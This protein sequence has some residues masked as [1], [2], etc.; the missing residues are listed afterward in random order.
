MRRLI[1][2]LLLASLFINLLVGCDNIKYNNTKSKNNLISESYSTSQITNLKEEIVSSSL[3]F[4]KF[5]KQYNPQCVRKTH[6]GYY[7]ILKQEDGQTAF[8]FINKKLEL[9]NML[10]IDEFKK[11]E[12]FEN[13]VSKM[14]TKSEIIEYDTNTIFSPFS[15]VSLTVH[16]VQEGIFIIKYSRLSDNTLLNDP[17]ITNVEFFDNQSLLEKQDVFGDSIPYIL[18]IDKRG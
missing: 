9:Y 1:N 8:I 12:E 11:K 13:Q 6:Q 15:S 4:T 16:I 17:I 2:C 3:S 7:V 14:S 5:K 10:I 18:E